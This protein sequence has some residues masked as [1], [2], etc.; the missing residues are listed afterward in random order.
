MRTVPR[1]LRWLP[2]PLAVAAAVVGWAVLGDTLNQHAGAHVHAYEAG[3]LSLSVDQ[4]VW[5]SNDMS[6]QGPLASKSQGFAMDPAMMPG[7]Q[8][9]NDNR[10][11]VEVTLRN[12]SAD[13][14][15]Y[16]FSDFHV[17]ALNGQSWGTSDDGGHILNNVAMLGPGYQATVD[18]YFDIPVTQATNDLSVEWSRAGNTVE[19][20]VDT[21]GT[22][23]PHTH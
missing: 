6:G 7:M 11:R 20:P 23:V 17:V 1:G 18:L 13:E 21:S 19:I 4:M 12:V 14:Q 9:A 5:M 16:A 22:P 10:L 2:L 3:G 15:R 8:A